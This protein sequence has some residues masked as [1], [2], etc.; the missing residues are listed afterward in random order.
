MLKR[1]ERFPDELFAGNGLAHIFTDD[2]QQYLDIDEKEHEFVVRS[3]L[4]QKIKYRVPD[5]I[6]N[7]QSKEF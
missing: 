3:T 5:H 6:M 1:L 4:D 7:A 2:L